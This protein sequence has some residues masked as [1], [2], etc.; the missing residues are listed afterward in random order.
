MIKSIQQFEEVGVKKLG[1]VLEDFINKPEKQAEFIYGVTDSV[2][3]LGLDI[4]KETLESMD[5]EL[6]KSGLRK[7]GWVIS[8][9]DETSLITSLG[10]VKYHKTLFK[11]K[12]SGICEYLLDKVMGLE[13]HTRMTEDAEAQMLEEA[14]DSSYRKGGINVSLSDTVSKQT[15]KNKI[16]SLKFYQENNEAVHKK[17]VDYLYIDADEDHVSLQYLESKGD[18]EKPRSNTSMP[19]LAYVYEGIEP[20]AP[21]SQRMKLINPKYF[22]GI[23][24]GSKG[25]EQFWRE[26]YDYIQST[27]DISKIKHIYINGDGANWIKTGRK[28]ISGSIFVLDKF[29]M[30]KYI[31][32]ATS[33]LMDS[34]LDARSEIY[35]A[36]NKRVKWMAQATFEKILNVTETESQRKKV[37][38][39]ML[40]I[41]GNWNGIIRGGI[42]K[43]S[44]VGCSAEGHVSHIY[45]DRMSSRPLGWS[46]HGVNQMSKLRI[47][48]ANKG[49][50][51]ELVRMQKQE[52]QLAAGAEEEIICMSCEM[53]KAE[54]TRLKEEQRY[55]ERMTHSIPFPEVKKIA[56]FKHHIWG[57]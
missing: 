33:H 34:A 50:M 28:W 23:Y 57:L 38:T 46:R 53:F 29:H 48:K 32:K 12:E 8:R 27:Y 37:E 22:G 42:N 4:I 47:Y 14:V 13:S 7:S 55:L 54:R 9:K 24:E 21:K 20:D 25:V 19:K 6:R 31:I 41:L 1:K 18:I 35:R 45:S 11:N 17:Q 26:I 56:Y 30:Q 43:D 40:Y 5:E 49:N 52:L 2:V 16:H 51:L 39:C 15:V 36:I 44:Q 10:T 3:R